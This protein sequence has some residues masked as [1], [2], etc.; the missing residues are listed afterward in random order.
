MDKLL[1]NV[2]GGFIGLA[3]LCRS[4]AWKSVRRAFATYDYQ[5]DMAFRNQILT[6]VSDYLVGEVIDRFEKPGSGWDPEKGAVSTW[7]YHTT[8]FLSANYIR[9]RILP[10]LGLVRNEHGDRDG[11][12]SGQAFDR[13]LADHAGQ[14]VVD[15]D[16]LSAAEQSRLIRTAVRSK[17]GY[18]G[19]VVL[20]DW[21][22]GIPA[23]ETARKLGLSGPSVSIARNAIREAV[24]G[25]LE[26]V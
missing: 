10:E 3:K 4:A 14:S 18:R 8:W 21:R 23:G 24:R 17:L 12:G 26:T 2:D 1:N 16:N 11:I 19:L 25:M 13:L 7:L 6:D 20:R 9:D 22:K 15:T 5:P